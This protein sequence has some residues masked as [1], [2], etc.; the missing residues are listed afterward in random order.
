MFLVLRAPLRLANEIPRFELDRRRLGIEGDADGVTAFGQRFEL[1]PEHPADHHDAAVALAKM[2][3][4]MNG[5]GA[6]ADLGFVVARELLVLGLASPWRRRVATVYAVGVAAR[7]ALELAR[8]PRSVPGFAASL[9]TMHLAWGTG[10][11]AGLGYQNTRP[12]AR[13]NAASLP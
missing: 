5:H 9:P 6:L 3:L 1:I 10:F 2:L 4:G 7:A 12:P 8:D 13:C 11:L